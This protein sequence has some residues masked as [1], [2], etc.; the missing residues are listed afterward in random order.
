MTMAPFIDKTFMLVGLIHQRLKETGPVVS[1]N[2]T[3]NYVN[4]FNHMLISR[5]ASPQ[6]PPPSGVQTRP[7]A[8]NMLVPQRQQLIQ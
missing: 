6:K 7:S 1:L 4:G 3:A 5:S 2:R 8:P